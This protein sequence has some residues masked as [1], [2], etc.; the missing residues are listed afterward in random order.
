MSACASTGADLPPQPT[1]GDLAAAWRALAA[2]APALHQVAIAM[3][4][5]DAPGSSSA[6]SHSPEPAAHED[7]T[8][9]VVSAINEPLILKA[10]SR[11][12]DQYLRPL[13]HCFTLFARGRAKR[14]PVTIQP[15]LR[16]WLDLGGENR[17]L[18]S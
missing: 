5:P 6:L 15:A 10:R 17:F 14:P 18:S 13:R 8:I 11:R 4:G 1:S 7:D 9:T 16:A 3:A 12:S 2:A